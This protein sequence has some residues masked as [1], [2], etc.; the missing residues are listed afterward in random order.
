MNRSFINDVDLISFK[1]HS[2]MKFDG[3]LN[4][5]YT[6]PALF[7]ANYDPTELNKSN[8][9]RRILLKDASYNCASI[10]AWELVSHVDFDVWLSQTLLPEL[11]TMY[12]QPCHVLIKRR[13]LILI[14][15][16]V[17]IKMNAENRV[18]VY[19]LLCECLQSS[20]DIVIRLQATLTLKA[21][22]DDVH[23]EKDSYLP[24]LN[25]HFGLLCQLLKE[26]EDG[27]TKIKVRFRFT[28]HPPLSILFFL[29]RLVS[30][31]HYIICIELDKL[32]LLMRHIIDIFQPYY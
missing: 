28:L 4:E 27:D 23:F 31:C 11:K 12:G 16:W 5:Q 2:R 22:M 10:A 9:D 1:L 29:L 3:T 6:N 7:P 18:I 25:Y 32:M 8:I 19:Q 13:I 21:V 15:N 17:N 24:Y 30:I 14:S 26:V 20:E